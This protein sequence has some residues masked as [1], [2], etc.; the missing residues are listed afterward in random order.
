M[1][2]STVLPAAAPARAFL[3]HPLGLATLFFTEMWERFSY[4]GTRA[5]LILFM[6]AAAAHG[7]L[8]ISAEAAGAVYGLYT[9]GV[10]L[11]SLPGGWIA[12]RI[13]GQRESVF[14]GGAL[15]SAGN[16]LLALPGGASLA[17]VALLVI[18]LGTGMLKPNCSVMVGELYRGDSGSRRDAGFSIFY[19]GINLGAFICPLVAGTIGETLGYRWGFATSSA[20]MVIG[21]IQYRLTARWLGEAGLAPHS[22]PAERR[23]NLRLLA[24]GAL[25]LAL[26]VAAALAGLIPLDVFQLASGAGVVMIALAV[27]VFGAMFAARGLTGADKRRVAVIALFF[28]CSALFWAGYEQA[29]S[30][31]NLFARDYTDRSLFGS[32]FAAHEHPVTW[33]Q[34]IEP[35][36]VLILAPLFAWL[37]TALGNRRR[38]PSAPIKLGLGLVQLGAGFAVMMLCAQLVLASGHKALPAWLVLTYLL[39]TTGELCLSPIGLSNVT[40]L[41][42]P[43]YVGQMMGTWFLGMAVGNLAA[44]LIGGEVGGGS[45]AAMPG[46]FLRMTLIGIVAGLVMLAISRRV[47]SW[48]GGVS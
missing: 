10:Y 18:A 43:R 2:E 8:G 40:K 46:Q 30:T 33:Y 20:A 39:H 41:A 25:V 3:G 29:G 19:C 9:A 44:G 11:A 32:Y 22:E 26:A 21:L 38:D 42:P 24:V 1:T 27:I 35:L 34:S 15:I 28:V 17:Y 37:W 4:Y 36:F 23:R 7:G 47:R 16:L 48:M 13:L 12:D 5:L 14:W 45:L 31:L 6:T